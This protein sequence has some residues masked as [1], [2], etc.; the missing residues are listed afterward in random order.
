MNQDIFA[1]ADTKILA[2][3]Q[4]LEN[5]RKY[6]PTILVPK[7]LLQMGFTNYNGIVVPI[8]SVSHRFSFDFYDAN[9]WSTYTLLCRT[10]YEEREAKLSEFAFRA[11]IEM[12]ID[13]CFILFHPAVDPIEKK[14]YVLLKILVDY[15]S[16][17]TGQQPL[18]NKW[19]TNLM[20]EEEDFIDQQY[21][22]KQKSV[23]QSLGE[24]I[25]KSQD[26]SYTKALIATR[27][28]C[29]QIKEE[30]INRHKQAGHLNLS[31][32]YQRMK[33]GEA[34]TIHGNIFLLPH[35]LKQQSKETHL[36]RVYTY[37]F[38]SGI[39]ALAG[40]MYFLKNDEFTKEA[41][42]VLNDLNSFKVVFSQTWANY[43]QDPR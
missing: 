22:D 41:T 24:N 10:V 17:E 16:I 3:L 40:V 27:R 12:G 1:L 18:F 28:L 30:I 15:S 33:S 34:H 20:G 36:F 43:Q 31:N 39:E 9:F 5:A 25:E 6:F 35:R 2:L 38:Y 8:D 26:D 11:L 14:K 4:T 23:L 37:L 29:M 21:T 42:A 32:A 19:F 7:Q 13:E